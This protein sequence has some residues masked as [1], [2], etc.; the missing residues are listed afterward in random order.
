MSEKILIFGDKEI[1]KYA[2]HKCKQPNDINNVDKIKIVIY[3]KNSYGEKGSFIGYQSNDSI[4]P[5]D[6]YI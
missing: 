3:D 5:L 1:S 6:H 4:R 2:I